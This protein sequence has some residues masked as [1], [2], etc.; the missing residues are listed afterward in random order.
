VIPKK[1]DRE[2]LEGIAN[3]PITLREFDIGDIMPKGMARKLEIIQV[4]ANAPPQEGLQLV[5]EKA[6]KVFNAQIS[7][8]SLS[9]DGEEFRRFFRTSDETQE[10]PA[11]NC[12]D[13]P[14][15]AALKAKGPGF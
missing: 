3:S 7:I 4:Y 12:I 13:A 11:V 14:I 9:P 10:F 15:M 5:L 6:D 2:S 8:Y 1:K